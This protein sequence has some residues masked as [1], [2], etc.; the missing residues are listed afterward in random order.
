MTPRPERTL[1]RTFQGRR[2]PRHGAPS[3]QERVC[4]RPGESARRP[5]LE[6]TGRHQRLRHSVVAMAVAAALAAPLAS[7][8]TPRPDTSAWKCKLCV[9]YTGA[10]AKVE[11]G[12]I[13]ADGANFASG[14]YSGLDHG[15]AYLQAGGK[16]RWRTRAGAYGSFTAQRLGLSSRHIAVTVGEEGRY[17]VHATY[18]GQPFDQ[19]D[20]AVT[21]YRRG[22]GGEQVLPAGWVTSNST[23]GMT[24]LQANLAFVPIESDRRTV[25]LSGRYFT[26]RVWTLFGKMSHS[27]RTGTDATGASFLTQA[28]QLPEPID[29]VTNNVHMGALWTDAGASVRIAYAGSW[30]DDKNDQLLFQ[31]PY[32]PLV[33]GSTSGLLSLPPDNNLQQ[34][35]VSGEAVLPLWSGVLSYVASVG[36]LAQDGSFIPGSTLTADPVLLSGSLPGDI[37]LTHY[38]LALALRPAA[39]LDLR[40]RATYDGRD[41]HAAVFAIP[42]VVTDALPGG[43]AVTPRYGEDRT[44]LSGSADYHL[45]RWVRVGLGGHYAHTHYAPGQVLT[46]LSELKAWGEAT[47][48][49]VAAVSITVKG[50]SS[51]RDASRFHASAL[52]PG[53]NPLLLAYDYAPRDREFL[54]VRAT[55]AIDA[56]LAWSLEGSAATDAYR[57]SQFGLSDGRQREISSTLSWSPA[58]P[59]SVYLEGSY[60]HLEASQFALQL[61]ASV[62][63]QAR[64]GEYFWTTATGGTWTVSTRWRLRADYMHARS[65]SDTGLQSLGIAQAFPQQA[66]TLDTVKVDADYRWSEALSLRLR[67][68]RD[69]FG[70]SDWALQSVYPGTIP[71]LLALGMQPYRYTVDSI[72]VSFIYRL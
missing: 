59:W 29:Y 18:Q 39:R 35:S 43:I 3:E 61:P 17:E 33:P 71:T 48:T 49:P 7:A 40:G 67:Y 66:T 2:T 55:W 68:A 31:N 21:P 69:Q 4:G 36:R 50:G 11:A 26:S 53:E 65:R 16:G 12:V 44:R 57:L 62:G 54:T 52:P 10:K 8:G 42:Y 51:R 22:A 30:F 72:A 6:A 14:R 60:E 38:A 24:A 64:E 56:K 47:L 28:L 19:Y 63:W 46:S 20:D 37:A 41:D 25:T 32:E 45:F 27:E 34:A 13:Y 23:R 15:G 70:S 58:K 9:F 1:D 5:Q